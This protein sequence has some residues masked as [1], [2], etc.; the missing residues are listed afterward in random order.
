VVARR[1]EEGPL[2]R[3]AL[4]CSGA[5]LV[6]LVTRRSAEELSLEPGRQVAALVKAPAVRLVP[7]TRPA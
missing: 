5:T 4:E 7:R 1:T 3:I 6:A 2:V